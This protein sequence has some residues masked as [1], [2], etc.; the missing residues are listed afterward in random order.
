MKSSVCHSFLSGKLA[1]T[2][3]VSVYVSV[4]GTGGDESGSLA[5]GAGL[6][7]FEPYSL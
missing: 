6:D 1:L 7:A 5:E 2:C 4:S 3:V